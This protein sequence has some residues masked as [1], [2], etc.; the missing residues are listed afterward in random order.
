MFPAARTAWVMACVPEQK[1]RNKTA[2]NHARSQLSNVHASLLRP[3]DGLHGY[4]IGAGW[5]T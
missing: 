1:Q 2:M 3:G 4:D 5:G